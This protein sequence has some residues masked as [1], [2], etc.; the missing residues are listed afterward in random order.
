MERYILYMVRSLN[1]LCLNIIMSQYVH[2]SQ[3]DL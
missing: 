2:F 1:M 3:I